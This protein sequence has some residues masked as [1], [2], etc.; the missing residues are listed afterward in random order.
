MEGEEENDDQNQNQKAV[1]PELL[2]QW[3]NRKRL[4]RVKVREDVSGSGDQSERSNDLKRIKVR[5]NRRVIKS[6]KDSSLGSAWLFPRSFYS[7]FYFGNLLD[8]QAIAFLYFRM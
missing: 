8:L 4:R 3:G 2:L 5:L 1:E 7:S 6:G